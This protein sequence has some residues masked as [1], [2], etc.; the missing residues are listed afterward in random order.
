ME[1]LLNKQ[2]SEEQ[3]KELIFDLMSGTIDLERYP[4]PSGII[5]E[6]EYAK[7]KTCEKLYAEVYDANRRICERLG[8]DEDQDVE[9]IISC[10]DEICRVFAYKMFDYGAKK[11][12]FYQ[13]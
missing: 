1:E 9:T 5:V 2:L 7:G 10:M 13:K 4:Y 6:N 8:V 12:V 11:E 3:L